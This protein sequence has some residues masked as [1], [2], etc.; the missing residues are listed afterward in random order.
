MSGS[1]HRVGSARS[2]TCPLFPQL[3]QYYRSAI[4]EAMFQSRF[5]AKAREGP[6]RVSSVRFFPLELPQFDAAAD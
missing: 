4:V 2:A 5:P 1:G 3:P 6:R